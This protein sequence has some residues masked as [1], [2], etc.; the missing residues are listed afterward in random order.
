MLFQKSLISINNYLELKK[1]NGF[2][3][4]RNYRISTYSINFDN[5]CIQ[6]KLIVQIQ[7]LWQH[8]SVRILPGR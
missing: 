2:K 8:W 4:F 5:V 3:K 6:S 7:L 1:R